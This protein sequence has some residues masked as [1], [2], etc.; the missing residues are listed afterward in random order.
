MWA[1]NTE[2]TPCHTSGTKN[3]EVAPTY[4]EKLCI[5]IDWDNQLRT[6]CVNTIR[7]KLHLYAVPSSLEN[8]RITV[9]KTNALVLFPNCICSN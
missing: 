6:E 5:Q 7:V 2:L 4:L 1:H 8:V 9:K 3:F